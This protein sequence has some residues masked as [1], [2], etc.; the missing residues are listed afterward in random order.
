VPR[1]LNYE[2]PDPK[3]PVNVVRGESLVVE[4]RTALALNQAETGHAVAVAIAGA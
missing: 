4:K 1:T 2:T 3:C